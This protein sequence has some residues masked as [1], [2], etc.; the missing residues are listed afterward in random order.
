MGFAYLATILLLVIV[1]LYLAVRNAIRKGMAKR[2]RY[3]MQKA[4]FRRHRE[5][6]EKLK[7][8][9]EIEKKLE[10]QA[11]QRRHQLLIQKRKERERA[12]EQ[13]L[14]ERLRLVMNN[15]LIKSTPR[16]S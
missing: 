3:R 5:T 9:K 11:I 16:N 12:E 2:R 4:Y 7:S 10:E 14:R 6:Q 8:V 13:A 1:N 15:N